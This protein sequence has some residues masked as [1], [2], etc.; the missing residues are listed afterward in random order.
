MHQ[1]P[2]LLKEEHRR[3]L[4]QVGYTPL[5][6]SSIFSSLL[7][8][9]YHIHSR[10]FLTFLSSLLHQTYTFIQIRRLK[11]ESEAAAI[12]LSFNQGHEP[13]RSVLPLSPSPLPSPLPS[14]SPSPSPLP[15]PLLLP[16]P[17]SLTLLYIQFQN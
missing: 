13:M 17:S 12:N 14:P 5:L 2:V 10:F 3:S 15:L 4:T 8:L 6:T 9:S 7:F 11:M 1:R 16:L